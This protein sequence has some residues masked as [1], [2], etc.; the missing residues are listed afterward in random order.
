MV[1]SKTTHCLCEPVSPEQMCVQYV[2]GV[3]VCACAPEHT[4]GD[5]QVSERVS[6]QHHFVIKTTSGL[7]RVGTVIAGTGRAPA[8]LPWI[9]LSF[10]L[11]WQCVI[12]CNHRKHFFFL[13]VP[14][15]ITPARTKDEERDGTVLCSLSRMCV[16]ELQRRGN[17]NG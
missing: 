4:N 2:L 16:S 12:A 8:S 13:P 5:R 1:F 10:P 11:P 6:E 3:C 17:A 7:I 14:L 15:L 9:R